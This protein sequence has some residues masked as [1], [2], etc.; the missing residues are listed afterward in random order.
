MSIDRLSQLFTAQRA[1]M[2]RHFASAD[3]LMDAGKHKEAGELLSGLMTR[4]GKEPGPVARYYAEQAAATT[5]QTA[6]STASKAASTAPKMASVR[7]GGPAIAMASIAAIGLTGALLY[8]AT[9]PTREEPARWA[10]RIT[11][12]RASGTAQLR[13]H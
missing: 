10:D 3:A 6:S 2:D 5:A 11:A 4:M 7:A 13:G 1:D 8:R 9:R 12:E